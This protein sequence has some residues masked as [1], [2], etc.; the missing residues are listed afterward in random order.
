MK[1]RIKEQLAK[2]DVSVEGRE[3]LFPHSDDYPVLLK[4]RGDH[5]PLTIAE[6]LALGEALIAEANRALSR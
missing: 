4:L 3:G 6:A 1:D 5:R 2:A